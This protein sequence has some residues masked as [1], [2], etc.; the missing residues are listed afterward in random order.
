MIYLRKNVGVDYRSNPLS[1]N[2]CVK[3]IKGPYKGKRGMI[4]CIF[5]K[6]VF[7]YNREFQLTQGIFLDHTSNLELLGSELLADENLEHKGKIN[8]LSIPENLK[9]LIGKTVKI[10]KGNYKG[11][12]GILRMADQQK[13]RVELLSRS[14][15]IEVNVDD[16]MDYENKEVTNDFYHTPR[17]YGGNVNNTPGYYPQ[18]PG[19][20]GG[21]N[22]TQSPA[23]NWNPMTPRI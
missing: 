11:H 20:F 2:D 12:A 21:G 4:K 8:Y 22:T 16:I 1:V 15:K 5:K 19:V 13:A 23:W 14:K 6:Q 3:V 18:T 17:N 7:L 9:K 10:I